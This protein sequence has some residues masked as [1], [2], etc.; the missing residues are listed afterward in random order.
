M[1][2]ASSVITLSQEQS[3][4]AAL[5]IMQ[6]HGH[7]ALPVVHEGHVVGV[8]SKQHIYKTFFLGTFPSKDEFLQQK[9][10]QEMKTDFR[11]VRAGDLLE[12][13]LEIMAVMRMQFLTVLNE[14]GYFTGLLT[15][16]SLLETL[17]NSLG[18]GKRGVRIEIVIN[19]AEGRL[20]ALTKALSRA[21]LNIISVVLLDP[22]V[23]DLRKIVMRLDTKEKDEV[24]SLVEKEGFRVLNAFV[25]E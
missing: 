1:V 6:Q 15:K 16:R 3:L 7:D 17:G 14:E 10:Q 23:M 5:K 20:A 18:M 8:L 22:E 4:Q 2:P 21:K 19:D 12:K 13:A 11:T 24:I 9:V 25:E